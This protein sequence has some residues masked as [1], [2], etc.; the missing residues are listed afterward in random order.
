MPIVAHV[1]PFPKRQ[2]CGV[3]LTAFREKSLRKPAQGRR[4]SDTLAF[5]AALHRIP[6]QMEVL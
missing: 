2:S 5:S 1:L 4:A 6:Y 3:W